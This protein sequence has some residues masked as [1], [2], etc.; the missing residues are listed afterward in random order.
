MWRRR[1][2]ATSP[3][4]SGDWNARS[5]LFTF[6]FM[7]SRPMLL[8]S[9]MSPGMDEPLES[10]FICSSADVEY[11]GVVRS[12]YSAAAAR[13]TARLAANHHQRDRHLRSRSPSRIPS[14]ACAPDP[15]GPAALMFMLLSISFIV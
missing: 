11:S 9:P 8:K 5:S 1:R 4:R 13:H 7:V 6:D 15:A 2:P 3:I 14:S 12:M 10:D